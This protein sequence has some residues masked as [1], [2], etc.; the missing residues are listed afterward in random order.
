MLSPR[1][2]LEEN[3]HFGKNTLIGIADTGG[4]QPKSSW[5]LL[6]ISSCHSVQLPCVLASCGPQWY[7]LF[8]GWAS[9]SGSP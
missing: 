5:I 7:L 6:P 2:P 3:I 4:A 9:G 1:D 8:A